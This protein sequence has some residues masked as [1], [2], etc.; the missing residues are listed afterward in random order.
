MQRF[1]L[2]TKLLLSFS[3]VIV[4]S[5]LLS[6]IIGTYLVKTIIAQAQGKV[7]LDLNSAREV[8]QEESGN[9]K[10]VVRLT[11]VRFFIKDAVLKG[12]GEKLKGELQNIRDQEHLDVLTLVN[13]QSRVILRA[14]NP[15]VF[16][17]QLNDDVVSH[18][19]SRQKVVVSTQIVSKDDLERESRDLLERS[20]IDLIPTLQE[21]PR[22][23]TEE[24][25]GMMIKAAAPV[26]DY[27]GELIGVLLG[28]RLLNRNYEIVD[29]VKDIVYRGEKYKGKDI[30]TVTIFQGDLRISTNVLRL[31]GDRAIG[32]RVSQEVYDQVIGKGV[33]WIGR[34]FVVNDWYIT[35]YEP[36]KNISGNIIG[37]LY[38]GI[39]EAPYV[40]LKNRAVLTFLG[41]AILSVTL[42]AIV[43]LFTTENI[44]RPLKELLFATQKVAQGN[45]SHRLRV[46]SG[47]EIGQLVGSFNQMTGE[48]QKA[49]E[50]YQVLTRTLEDKVAEKTEELRKAQDQ[51]IQTAKLTSLGKLAAGIAHEVNNPLTSI[52][53]NSHL[54]AEKLSEDDHFQE[55][56]RLII[57]ETT[58]CGAIV[59]G[60][61]DFS[62]QT[63]PEKNISDLNE[64]VEN[65]L[66]MLKSQILV[67]EIQVKKDLDRELPEIMIDVNQI[68]QVFTNMILNALDATPKGGWLTVRSQMASDKQFVEITFQ[69]TGH[70]IEKGNIGKIFDPF[71]TTKGMAGSG[72]GLSVSYG[73]M[74][75][76][77]GTIDVQS[78]PGKG[79]TMTIQLPVT[80]YQEDEA[81]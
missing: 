4:V 46:K 21:R 74:R 77:G 50:K 67:H 65:T 27:D 16:G 51:L 24:T 81:V 31:D 80:E 42:L 76:H 22:T 17:D 30:G 56:M 13:R 52:L 71:Y 44:T 5:A 7:K 73:I 6:L 18:V 40:D 75:Q 79:T 41:V 26:L 53:I 78:E 61:L 35:A 36:I 23:E 62:R 20:R 45:L 29:N 12:H 64:V 37:M 48:L 19:L 58:R 54:V 59:K 39:L 10:D 8:Y 1:S 72:L 9:I 47:D 55:N 32:T 63:P 34:A 2:R 38:V 43:A 60:L 69:D 70:G 57:D 14:H 33:P 66:Q 3:T 49:T 25:S 11:A 28:G 68:K 15:E